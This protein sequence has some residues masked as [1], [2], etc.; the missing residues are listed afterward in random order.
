[1]PQRGPR[2]CRRIARQDGQSLNE[3]LREVTHR[4]KEAGVVAGNLYTLTDHVGRVHVALALEAPDHLVEL[5]GV[6]SGEEAV[7]P[8]GY[9]DRLF[10]LAEQAAGADFRSPCRLH[11][12]SVGAHGLAEPGAGRLY[13][14]IA[15]QLL[16]ERRRH[17]C[18][19]LAF[20]YIL[21]LYPCRSLGL[22]NLLPSRPQVGTHLSRDELGWPAAKWRERV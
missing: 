19:A 4:G 11:G 2:P 6:L 17:R 3:G 13:V 15:S 18:L 22:L 1:M 10:R 20:S 5:V 12:A 16:G 9:R 21:N 8:L 7:A 14:N